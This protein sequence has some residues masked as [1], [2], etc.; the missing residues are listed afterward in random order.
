M[1]F[2][3]TV[4]LDLG[5][6]NL[7]GTIR[8]VFSR[9]S[10]LEMLDVSANDFSGSI[11]ESLFELPNIR[12][13]H[14]FNNR[15]DGTIPM[16]YGNA[17]RLESLLLFGNMLTGTVPDIE[18]GELPSLNEF[19]MHQNR[20]VGSMPPSVCELRVPTLGQLN[21]LWADCSEAAMPMIMRCD[22]PLCCTM[23]FP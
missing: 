5:G 11:P 20:L 10:S 3:D 7:S 12:T 21:E 17:Q 16:M 8:D 1:L 18:P 6:N 4:T 2:Y 19:L 22:Q 9:F 23:C 15:L 13:L 14:F